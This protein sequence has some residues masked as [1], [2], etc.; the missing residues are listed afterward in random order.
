MS[1]KCSDYRV[2][3][4]INKKLHPGSA[5]NAIA[6]L[7]LGLA[8]HIGENGRKQLSFLN[9][10]DGSGD[11]HPSIS[12]RSLIV[13]RGTSG[14]IQKLRR[15]VIER[16]LPC[17]DFIETMTGGDYKSQLNRTL[18]EKDD[19]LNYYG[20]AILGLTEELRPLTK[21]FSLWK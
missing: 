5:L 13:L 6:H 8:A 17:V 14:Q 12:A 1:N 16:G 4:V 18:E 2:I 21:K 10:I 19:E 9:F 11:N 15:N 20:V 3:A 7:G